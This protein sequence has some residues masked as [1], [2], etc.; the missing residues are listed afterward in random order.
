M[1]LYTVMPLDAIPLPDR[2]PDRL[3]AYSTHGLE[4]LHLFTEHTSLVPANIRPLTL[5]SSLGTTLKF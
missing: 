1:V 4:L 3:R 2:P 5:M